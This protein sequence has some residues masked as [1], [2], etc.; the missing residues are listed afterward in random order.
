[1]SAPIPMGTAT[2]RRRAARYQLRAP[3]TF[4]LVRGR[5]VTHGAGFVY[6]ISTE[7]VFV[8]CPLLPA[9]GDLI[10]IEILLLPFETHDAHLALRST[11]LVVRVEDKSGFAVAA[12]FKLNRYILGRRVEIPNE[13]A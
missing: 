2:E 12:K 8:L 6:D 11:G 3:V 10:E 5:I 4:K 7:S 13:E 1:M 9:V